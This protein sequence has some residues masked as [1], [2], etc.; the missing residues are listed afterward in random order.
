MR[1]SILIERQMYT[2]ES[3][4]CKGSTNSHTK[5]NKVTTIVKSS[6]RRSWWS[7][8]RQA[9]AD[10]SSLSCALRSHCHFQ[11]KVASVLQ[12]SIGGGKW[13]GERKVRGQ[14]QVRLRKRKWQRTKLELFASAHQ[15]WYI[16]AVRRTDPESEAMRQCETML[17]SQT[18]YY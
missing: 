5:S 18:G 17:C 11:A 10:R 12:P 8:S 1:Q 14:R 4:S 3:V 6:C 16:A 2:Q 15:A 13:R 7:C 9:D